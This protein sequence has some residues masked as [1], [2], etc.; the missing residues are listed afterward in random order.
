MN[1]STIEIVVYGQAIALLFFIVRDFFMR[2]RN[3]I[4]QHADEIK[5]NTIALSELRIEIRHLKDAIKMLPKIERDVDQAHE[6]LRRMGA[7][8]SREN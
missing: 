7:N 1:P 3:E 8:S 5:L 6:K 2:N 4:K